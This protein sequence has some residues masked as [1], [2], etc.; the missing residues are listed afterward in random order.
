MS[1]INRR[2]L[3][4]LLSVGFTVATT[5]QSANQLF[6]GTWTVKSFGN[7]CA[8]S[9]VGTSMGVTKYPWCNPLRTGESRFYSDFGLPMGVQCNPNQ[10]RCPFQSTPTD[11]AGNFAPLGGSQAHG[12]FCAPW[13]NFGGNGTTMRPAKGMT[14]TTGGKNRRPI[15]PLYRREG[16][17]TAEGAPNTTFCTA[18]ST[19]GFGGKGLVQAGNPITGSVNA[20]TTA[21]G[22][23][24]FPAAPE[25]GTA[26]LRA[27]GVV[28]EFG[29]LYPY[30]YSYTYVTMRNASGFFGP[31]SGLGN[32]YLKLPRQ[33]GQVDA[34]IEIKQGA[35]KFGG[36]MKM[37]GAL[38]TKVCYY[39]AGGC[40]LGE[41]NWR[42]EAAG[43]TGNYR[44]A[45]GK[46]TKGYQALNT[47]IYFNSGVGAF[48]S[49]QGVGSR[50]GWTTGSITV[51][52]VGRGPH[53]TIHY[54]HGYDNRTTT[55]MG[56][57]TGTIQLV[58]P[59]LTQW[60]QPA[61]KWET[62]GIGILKL[63][64]APEPQTWMMLAAGVSLLGV[65]FRMRGR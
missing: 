13:V 7:E 41:N 48:S 32:A 6:E 33:G 34:H 14:P 19:D 26:G 1:R 58:T 8:E 30:V 21:K 61:A 9:K 29:A 4:G 24:N 44:T 54:A 64:F 12:M 52:A 2:L 22:G 42:Y 43:T 59:L 11:G 36:T 63:K 55:S 28:G 15:P 39:R 49:V 51:T 57:R 35:A 37:L 45:G 40:S 10:P 5:A 38:T 46:I 56:L 53:K 47:A 18:V 27:T 17:F 62:G 25:S 23:F 60:L 50:L 16:F 3:V 20:V 31:G 65:G